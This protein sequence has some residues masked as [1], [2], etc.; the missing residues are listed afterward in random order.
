MA[1]PT[2]EQPTCDRTHST[3]SPTQSAISSVFVYTCERH[4]STAAS[5]PLSAFSMIPRKFHF[6]KYHI[7]MYFLKLQPVSDTSWGKKARFDQLVSTIYSLLKSH[8]VAD[9]I[10]LIAHKVTIKKFTTQQEVTKVMHRIQSFIFNVIHL[11]A[12]VFLNMSCK[13]VNVKSDKLNDRPSG[14]TFLQFSFE[15][16]SVDTNPRICQKKFDLLFCL[17]FPKHQ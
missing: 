14:L 12:I 11:Q 6:R 7:P 16:D 2:L 9:L 8:S 10:P 3:M 1:P 17:L 5:N 4:N 13:T 15:I